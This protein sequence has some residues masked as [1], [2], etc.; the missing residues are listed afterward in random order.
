MGCIS[1]K[2]SIVARYIDNT[3]KVDGI[4]K[5]PCSILCESLPVELASFEWFDLTDHQNSK[6]LSCFVWLPMIEFGYVFF[7]DSRSR[8][9]DKFRINSNKFKWN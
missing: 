9:C 5:L 4:L 3:I 2:F 1:R 8:Q 7:V 6:S